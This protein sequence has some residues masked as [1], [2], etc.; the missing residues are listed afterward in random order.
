M[1]NYVPFFSKAKQPSTSQVA[2]KRILSLCSKSQQAA[3]FEQL[4]GKLV[5]STIKLCSIPWPVAQNL[6]DFADGFE[7]LEKMIGW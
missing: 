1:W 3:R 6:T 4:G 7:T 2:A 5:D